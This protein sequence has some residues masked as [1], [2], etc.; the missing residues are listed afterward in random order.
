LSISLVAASQAVKF[1]IDFGRSL[2]QGVARSEQLT[3]GTYS[4]FGVIRIQG[5]RR[6]D[7][8]CAILGSHRVA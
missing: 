5:T 1:A 7:G 2:L 8:E 4:G 6:G 3:C